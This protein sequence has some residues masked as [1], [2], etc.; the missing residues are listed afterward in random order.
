MSRRSQWEW[1]ARRR[2][3]SQAALGHPR[4]F[5]LVWRCRTA[6]TPMSRGSIMHHGRLSIGVGNPTARWPRSA[7]N[8]AHR[9]D[10]RVGRRS[11]STRMARA[12]AD[13]ARLG[14]KTRTR[15]QAQRVHLIIW[16][17]RDY[18]H[19][20]ISVGA[21]HVY[22]SMHRCTHLQCMCTNRCTGVY[23]CNACVHLDAPVYRVVMHVYKSMHRCI[24]L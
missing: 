10:G 3:G 19:S 11:D 7:V 9:G 2:T 21:M 12:H 18:I 16:Y 6:R 5:A 20:Y 4:R 22:N 1:A 14:T 17:A 8:G 24:E 13:A 23:S 15:T